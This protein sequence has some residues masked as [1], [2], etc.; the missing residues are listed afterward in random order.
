MRATAKAIFQKFIFSGSCDALEISEPTR[1]KIAQHVNDQAL[2]CGLFEEALSEIMA[3]MKNNHYPRFMNT[4]LYKECIQ[5]GG[6]SPQGL[7]ERYP[8][9]ARFH[10][11]YLPTLPEEKVLGFDEIEDDGDQFEFEQHRKS[12]K[13]LSLCG[14]RSGSDEHNARCLLH[15]PMNEMLSPYHYPTAPVGSRIESEN[16]SLSSDAMTEDTLSVTTDSAMTDD[17]SSRCSGRRKCSSRSKKSGHHDG[18][19]MMHFIPRTQRIPKDA[20]HP[21]NPEEFAKILIEKLEKVKLEQ[22]L[23]EREAHNLSAYFEA[24]GR[25]SILQQA[26]DNSKKLPLSTMAMSVVPDAAVPFRETYHND[27]PVAGVESCAASTSAQSVALDSFNRHNQPQPQPQQVQRPKQ[28]ASE[29]KETAVELQPSAPAKGGNVWEARPTRKD[30]DI[31]FITVNHHRILQ[32]MEEGEQ[33]HSRV[34]LKSANPTVTILLPQEV[35]RGGRLLVPSGSQRRV[36][37]DIYPINPS[38]QIL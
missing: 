7:C 28:P 5:S 13:G 4:T 12:V 30:D 23:H 21:S 26:I 29:V 36:H 24:P 1:T 19:P 10:G 31:P 8:N 18:L 9:T 27:N 32:W 22:E 25:K 35:A 16:Q 6:E 17:A 15:I 34:L 14:K 11:G 20:R 38:P 3:N 33:K 37:L 2:D